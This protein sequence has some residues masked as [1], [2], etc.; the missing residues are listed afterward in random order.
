MLK[1]SNRPLGSF[2]KVRPW[3]SKNH[4]SYGFKPEV[5]VLPSCVAFFITPHRPGST[6]DIEIFKAFLDYHLEFCSKTEEDLNKE[7][8]K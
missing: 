4:A 3:F 8:K 7:D 1:K 2:D 5:S 6:P